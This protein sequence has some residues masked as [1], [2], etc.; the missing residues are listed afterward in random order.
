MCVHHIKRS[1]LFPDVVI[2]WK[3]GGGGEDNQIENIT[4]QLVL[5]TGDYDDGHQQGNHALYG[6]MGRG[7]L[8]KRTSREETAKMWS[9]HINSPLSYHL[10]KPR[11]SFK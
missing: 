8:Q 6:W 9:Q 4:K 10:I 11:S 7:P 2:H 5:T 1:Y 3:G